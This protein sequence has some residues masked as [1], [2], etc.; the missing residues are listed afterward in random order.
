MA[1]LLGGYFVLV[2]LIFFPCIRAVSNTVNVK[3]A[4]VLPQSIDDFGWNFDMHRALL[5]L[6]INI[7]GTVVAFQE[8][9]AV[10]D[11]LSVVDNFISQ[12]YQFIW[13]GGAQ[14]AGCAHTAAEQNPSVFF[15]HENPG[16]VP[17]LPNY[18]AHHAD[19]IPGRFISGVMAG[20]LTATNRVGWLATNDPARIWFLNTFYLG[21]LYHNPEAE[22]HVFF[23]TSFSDPVN[24]ELAI[25]FAVNQT[26]CDI[27][28]QQTNTIFPQQLIH[29]LGIS[30]IGWAADMSQTEGASVL[31]SIVIFW[32]VALTHFVQKIQNNQ[33]TSSELF[34]L[35]E[36]NG[37]VDLA[38]FSSR[39]PSSTTHV[40][41]SLEHRI[42][43]GKNPYCG[44]PIHDMFGTHCL[45]P[46]QAPNILQLA[47][48]PGLIV[49]NYH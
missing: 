26:G 40:L 47:L 7:P 24:E 6:Q 29:D 14:Y 1:V 38:P 45:D 4:A 23:T 49:E 32:E 41:G 19:I 35:T 33:W 18:S 11:C 42:N 17:D 34:L 12:G 48:L 9:V 13:L 25:N 3:V 20:L 43:N 28:A 21:V 39:V 37:G 44:Q 36:E 5:Q 31:T 15:A 27:I 10:P 16:T 22:V 2:V 46:T 8:N 30:G